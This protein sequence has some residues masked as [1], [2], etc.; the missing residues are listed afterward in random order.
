MISYRIQSA[1]NFLVFTLVFIIIFPLSSCIK[2]EEK[3]MKVRN[4]S[5]SDVLN[6]SAKAHA[7]V[8]DLGSGIDQHGHCWSTSAELNI[9]INDGKSELGSLDNTGQFTSEMKDLSPDTKYYVRAYVQK[10]SSVIYGENKLSFRTLTISLPVVT[11]GTIKSVS[12]TTATVSGNLDSIGAGVSSV[13]QHGHCWSNETTT[14]TVDDNKTSLGP[15]DTIGSFESVIV[16]L[17]PGELYYVRAYATNNAGTAYGDTISFITSAAGTVPVLTTGIISNVTENSATAAGSLNNMGSGFS[18]VSQHGHCW[19]SETSTPTIND[20]KTSLGTRST[21]G[22]FESSL[23]GLT[24]DIL[25]YVRA[26]ATNSSGTG[27]GNPVSFSTEPPAGVPEL[28]TTPVSSITGTTATSGGSITSDGG[29]SIT[30]KG[31]CWSTNHNP[32]IYDNNK[33]EG[34]GTGAF[35]STM[36]GLDQKTIYYVRAYATNATDTGY[37]NEIAFTTKFD[38]GTRLTDP[39]DGKTYLTVQIG[40]QCWMAENLNVGEML[41]GVKTPGNN[42]LIEKHCYN[43]NESN[44]DLYGGIYTW[45]EMM[46]HT[47]IEMTTGICPKGWHIASDFEWKILEKELGMSQETVDSTGWRG[48]DEG[49]R[50]KAAGTT[51][52]EDPNTGATNS[53]LFT[54]LPAGHSDPDGNFSGLGYNTSYWTS[55]LIIDTQCYRRY[56]QADESR[57]YRADGNRTW[58]ASVRCV[59]D[60]E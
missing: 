57:I 31:I 41:S 10:S 42:D 37:G 45:D 34:N 18:S 9:D 24:P 5:I 40:D 19:S 11:T 48:T 30:A 4:D 17:S 33:N 27:Y 13:S 49:G 59:E 20:D 3:I 6:T 8:I 25:Y 12:E 2:E 47:E 44:C 29:S 53:S 26:Y 35:V 1:L 43:D 21:T 14:P 16:G 56:L 36:E 51:Y 39:R 15:K 23:T 28:T 52:W 46:D 60:Q 7:T 58:G 22:S 55:T 38:C 54:A 32:T 50:L